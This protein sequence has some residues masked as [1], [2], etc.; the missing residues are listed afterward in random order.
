MYE[1]PRHRQPSPDSRG[2]GEDSR[3]QL[4]SGGSRAQNHEHS[5][6]REGAGSLGR[7]IQ[8][9][10]AEEV[11]RN[12]DVLPIFREE[13]AC[14]DRAESSPSFSIFPMTTHLKGCT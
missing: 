13:I 6:A 3:P 10:G 9:R 4:R 8:G 2:N 11:P 5:E 12:P 1:R 7:R 14:P